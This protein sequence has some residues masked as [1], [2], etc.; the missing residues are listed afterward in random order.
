MA[1][2]AGYISADR[3][4]AVRDEC[5]AY[6]SRLRMIAGDRVS[7]EIIE[8]AKVLNDAFDRAVRDSGI[9]SYEAKVLRLDMIR[10]YGWCKSD[11][12]PIMSQ[13]TYVYH[14]RKFVMAVA[15]VMGI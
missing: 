3:Y 12:C 14:K 10:G 9:E 8:C 15:L 7:D 2:R 4:E 6:D 11:L 13:E 1:R 5:K